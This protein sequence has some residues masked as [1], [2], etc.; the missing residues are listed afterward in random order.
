[1]AVDGLGTDDPC[2]APSL[3]G[4]RATC[5]HGHQRGNIAVAGCPIER[6]SMHGVFGVY[7][8][9]N[10]DETQG[11]ISTAVSSGAHQRRLT[12]IVLDARVR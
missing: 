5:Q 12:P 1:M 11:H 7:R 10:I 9:S 2:F 8:T 4:I 3:A 6:C